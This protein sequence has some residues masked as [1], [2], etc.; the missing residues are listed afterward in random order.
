MERCDFRTC[1]EC[2]CEPSQCRVSAPLRFTKVRDMRGVFLPQT[3]TL[4][5][6][7]AFFAVSTV[8]GI[9][10]IELRQMER[11]YLTDART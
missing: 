11:Q 7:I 1:G 6:I 8:V 9:T 4:L 2:S 10:I 3:S 5:A